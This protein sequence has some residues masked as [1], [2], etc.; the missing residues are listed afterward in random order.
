VLGA[1]LLNG[2]PPKARLEVGAVIL[3]VQGERSLAALSRCNERL[4]DAEEV[5]RDLGERRLRWCE[6]RFRGVY[7]DPNGFGTEVFFVELEDALAWA[8]TDGGSVFLTVTD[9]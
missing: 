4:E 7:G 3:A 6:G 2:E 9:E 5:V 8:N 1:D